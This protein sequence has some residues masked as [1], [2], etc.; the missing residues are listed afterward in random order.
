MR[1]KELLTGKDTALF[2]IEGDANAVQAAQSLS[3]HNIGALLVCDENGNLT[4]ILS[5]RDIV[6]GVADLGSDFAAAGIAGLMSSDVIT[7]TAEDDVKETM[8][9]MSSNHIRHIPVVDGRRPAA[10]I[11]SRDIMDAL[12]DETS[13]QRNIMAS[14]YEMVR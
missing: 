11:S 6:R 12:L 8:A 14:A 9:I 3:A 4:G 5:E 7:C 13:S 10:I 1:I 2:T